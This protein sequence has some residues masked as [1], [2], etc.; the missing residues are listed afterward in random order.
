LTRFDQFH[1][2]IETILARKLAR[3]AK[4]NFA[5]LAA[6]DPPLPPGVFNRLADNWRPLFAIAQ[7]A[8][9]DW[10]Q[11]AI[12][13]FNHLSMPPTLSAPARHSSDSDGGSVGER[14]QGRGVA[15]Y[16]E[17][18]IP[19]STG[20]AGQA[21]PGLTAG[22]QD[23]NPVGSLL[24]DIF[25]TF[26]QGK[27]QRI[28]S[29]DLVAKL[30]RYTGRPWAEICNGKEITELWLAQMLR[31]YG[32]RPRTIWIGEVAAKGYLQDDF[33]DVFRRYITKS[34]GF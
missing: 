20:L 24:R 8:G 4:D 16:S 7:V 11:R 2:E 17:S 1:T 5:A 9:G 13:A 15:L 33:M 10:P 34:H 18:H 31:P 3:W 6:C 21:T 25:V 27:T 14:D 26:T 28:F 29:R 30:N 19:Q 32:I 22:A 12:A 23:H